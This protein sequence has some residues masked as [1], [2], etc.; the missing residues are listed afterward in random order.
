MSRYLDTSTKK[1]WPK[2]WSSMEDPVLPLERN[3]YG[4]PLA[5]LLWERQFEKVLLEHGWWKFQ[6]RNVDSLTK[7][8]NYSCLCMWTISK[9]QVRNRT[10]DPMWRTLRET[11]WFGRTDIIPWPRLFGL[12]SKR[13]SDKQ[14]YCGQLQK[15]VRIQHLYW[16]YRKAALFRETWREHFLMVLWYGRSCK[17]MHGKILRTG[18][19]NNSTVKQSRNSMYWRPPIQRRRNGICWR[20]V[21]R[22]ALELSKNAFMWLEAADLIFYGQ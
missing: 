21:N 7:K 9:W 19:Q 5:G 12:H 10:L 13:M 18:T 17:E 20:I 3:L 11:S 22:Y 6:I 1:K 8:K 16:S 2:S 4:H 14:R 15:Y